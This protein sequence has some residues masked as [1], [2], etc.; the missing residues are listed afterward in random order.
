MRVLKVIFIA[1][2]AIFITKSG[3]SQSINHIWVGHYS[4]TMYWES[5]N[6]K[7]DIPYLIDLRNSN[8]AKIKYFAGRQ[9][10]TN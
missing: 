8:V 2:I 10:E 9:I 6:M 1:I 7:S 3:N 5:D 4:L